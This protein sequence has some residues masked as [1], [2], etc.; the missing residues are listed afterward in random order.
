M[1]LEEYITFVLSRDYEEKLM[2]TVEEIL[3]VQWKGIDIYDLSERKFSNDQRFDS[4]L[5]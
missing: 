1:H 2:Q 4:I 3:A 5:Q